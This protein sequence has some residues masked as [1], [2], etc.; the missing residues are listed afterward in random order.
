MNSMEKRNIC[1]AVTFYNNF[2]PA[3][4]AVQS[5]KYCAFGV[6][7]GIDVSDDMAAKGEM[8]PDCIWVEQ[9]K[10]VL[11]LKGEYTAQQIYIVKYDDWEKDEGFW[12]DGEY[13][14]LF[15]LRIQCSGDKEALL[16]NRVTLETS[17]QIENE[18]RTAIYLTYDN[19]DLFVVMKAK[20]YEQGAGMIDTLHHKINLSMDREKSC[21]LKNSFTVF[22]VEHEWIDKLE[23]SNSRHLIAKTID[24]VLIKVIGKERGSIQNIE[25]ELE[26][27]KNE[28]FKNKNIEIDRTPVLGVDDELISV[29]NICWFDLFSLYKK[30]NNREDE[31]VLCNSNTLYDD[32]I[33]GATTVIRTKLEDYTEC[34]AD[35]GMAF[36][37]GEN[38]QTEGARISDIYNSQVK[39][40]LNELDN[41]NADA[42]AGGVKELRLILNALSK[43]GGEV[44]NDYIFFPTIGA[45]DAL[46]E[47]IKSN[48]NPDKEHF[49]DFLRG[50]SMYIQGSVRSDR[51]AMQAMDFNTKIYDIPNK[52]NAFYCAFI[53]NVKKILGGEQN[54]GE[55][56]E[57]DFLLVPGMGS[58]FNVIELYKKISLTRHLMKMEIPE[59]NFYSIHDTM[60][61]LSHEM[62][63][64]VGGKYRMRKERYKAVI[65]SY[66]HI[67][68]CYVRHYLNRNEIIITDEDAE[69]IELRAVKVI[70]LALERES[71]RDYL[72]KV[73]ISRVSEEQYKRIEKHNSDY[74]YYFSVVLPNIDK[75][76]IDILQYDIDNIFSPILYDKEEGHR[77]EVRKVILAATER[78]LYKHKEGSTL[79]SS[80]VALAELQELYEESFADLMSILL[81]HINVKDYVNAILHNAKQQGMDIEELCK[82]EAVYRIVVVLL[83]VLD[84]Q[85]DGI[86]S[87]QIFESFAAEDAE[88]KLLLTQ[89]I[90]EWKKRERYSAGIY[91]KEDYARDIMNIHGDCFVFDKARQYLTGCCKE[92]MQDM[93]K[94]QEAAK[95]QDVKKWQDVEQLRKVFREV[96]AS[97]EVSIEKQLTLVTKFIEKYREES[98]FELDDRKKSSV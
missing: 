77:Q 22:A 90:S 96:S 51:H 18:I 8:L 83:C 60:V 36:L 33:A 58:F 25:K 21:Y 66:A 37:S 88:G 50:F 80:S 13:P 9:K 42:D 43:F 24:E 19:S 91:L 54:Q 89:S 11:N 57:Y 65:V 78:F 81:L 69:I 23:E 48:K 87:N 46:L 93:E 82:S 84:N 30:G 32:N 5:W 94:W 73:K 38:T 31:G 47:L 98:L 14:F 17:L 10:S 61:I 3:N 41:V 53:Y 16:G 7:D 62:P 63:H 27:R 97:P 59:C 71:R 86:V 49:F 56:H 26:N 92:F 85:V 40:L 44:F 2:L 15:F 64:Y 6:V 39:R 29:K 76:M 35:K 74:Q 4:N 55:P 67:Y 20:F 95:Q 79:L 75:A 70:E 28:T 72:E 1:R 45:I 52:I 34:L 68:V 12:L